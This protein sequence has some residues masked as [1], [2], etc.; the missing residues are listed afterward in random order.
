M[1]RTWRTPA[2]GCRVCF[3]MA[4]GSSERHTDTISRN[5]ERREQ[6]GEVERDVV[7]F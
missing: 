3:D 4:A 6:R 1:A 5:R 2:H 7:L